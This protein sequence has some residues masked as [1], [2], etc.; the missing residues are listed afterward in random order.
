MKTICHFKVDCIHS[1]AGKY[2]AESFS[3]KLRHIFALTH[4]YIPR[5]SIS[6]NRVLL[7]SKVSLILGMAL[8]RFKHSLK[9]FGLQKKHFSVDITTLESFICHVGEAREHYPE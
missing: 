4:K 5:R 1:E 7:L 3:I 6:D 2:G 8:R 9:K